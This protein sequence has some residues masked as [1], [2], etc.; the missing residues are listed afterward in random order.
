LSGTDYAGIFTGAAVMIR[1]L[2]LIFILSCIPA[3]ASQMLWNSGAPGVWGITLRQDSSAEAIVQ[4]FA[5]TTDAIIDRIGVGIGSGADL[6]LTGFKV[7]ITS[8]ESVEDV[9]GSQIGESFH[10]LPQSGAALAYAYSDIQPVVLEAYKVYGLVIEPGDLQ[11]YGAVAYCWGSAYGWG[12]SDGWQTNFRLPYQTAV[13]VYG[14]PVPEPA[15]LFVLLTAAG[16]CAISASR[17]IRKI[18]TK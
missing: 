5:L 15:S 4:P 8:I 11:M 18:R 16:T 12:T 6:N 3:G 1:A 14:T 7:T 17:C 2:L 10:L 13:R 9:P